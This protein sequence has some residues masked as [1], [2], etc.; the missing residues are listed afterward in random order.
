MQ[1]NYPHIDKR[2]IDQGWG[3]MKKILDAKM[4]VAVK[5]EPAWKRYL[6]LLFFLL[7]G[8]GVTWG[9]LVTSE[10]FKEE[11]PQKEEK[12]IA[13]NIETSILPSKIE[14]KDKQVKTKEQDANL[15]NSINENK[16]EV[17]EPI[18]SVKKLVS[19]DPLES[20]Q[21]SIQ[22][23]KQD[24]KVDDITNTS[25]HVVG[26]KK[27]ERKAVIVAPSIVQLSSHNIPDL[28]IT[29]LHY[30]VEL[31]NSTAYSAD[32]K[33]D[34]KFSFKGLKIKAGEK[35]HPT[36]AVGGPSL[37]LVSDFKYKDTKIGFETGLNYDYIVAN[38]FEGQAIPNSNKVESSGAGNS[39]ILDYNGIFSPELEN[40]L[41]GIERAR[42]DTSVF[43][44][45]VVPV[46]LHYLTI[47]LEIYYRVGTRVKLQGG[48]N[49]AM[50]ASAPASTTG[51]VFDNLN[52]NSFSADLLS[53]EDNN[54]YNREPTKIN[55][56]DLSFS[57][58]S[59][60]EISRFWELGIKYHFGLVDPLG[61]SQ[62]KSHNRYFQLSVAYKF[63]NRK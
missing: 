3:E 8:I 39:G 21:S 16:L 61:L 26:A 5:K 41:I 17:I 58:G 38:P 57:V 44:F 27:E 56:F 53:A 19:N 34:S 22:K 23:R 28:P 50:L 35:F 47:P 33:K 49:I 37:G 1:D 52:F 24:F 45:I 13:K 25:L 51:G 32:S 29:E 2:T 31:E 12:P 48:L 10:F 40:S 36:K 6:L 63:H 59:F 54:E 18:K 14:Q 60:Y 30:Q 7:I 4:P 15:E 9:I 11:V 55:Q 43:N 62:V 46:A 42:G 20:N